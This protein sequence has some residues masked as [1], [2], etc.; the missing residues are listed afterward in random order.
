MWKSSDKTSEIRKQLIGILSPDFAVPRFCRFCP[1]LTD[2]TK[3]VDSELTRE[4]ASCYQEGITI[5]REYYYARADFENLAFDWSTYG[6]SLPAYE[7]IILNG[8]MNRARTKMENLDSD[9]AD[10]ES[11][12]ARIR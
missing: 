3:Y 1:I 5:E 9:R 2:I 7:L 4:K 6:T 8:K 10:R 12:C 11:Q